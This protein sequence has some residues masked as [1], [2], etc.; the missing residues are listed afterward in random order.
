MMKLHFLSAADNAALTKRFAQGSNGLEK[1]PYPLVRRLSS[2]E[3]TVG[4]IEDFYTVLCDQAAQGHCLLKGK[5]DRALRNE[6]RAGHTNPD[7][8]TQ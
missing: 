8:P 1:A 3:E 2:I 6:S 7:E 4:T 5:L